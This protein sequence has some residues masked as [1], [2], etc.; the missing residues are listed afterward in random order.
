MAEVLHSLVS[1]D[2]LYARA[3]GGRGGF[4]PDLMSLVDGDAA[5]SVQ[6]PL[7]A[8]YVELGM[9]TNAAAVTDKNGQRYTIMRVLRA[10][11]EI[12]RVWAALEALAAASAGTASAAA[13][14]ASSSAAAPAVS[15]ADA[16][17]FGAFAETLVKEAVFLLNDA[18]GRLTDVHSRQVRMIAHL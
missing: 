4:G 1:T 10:L 8:L 18:L 6:V 13:G 11:W 17:A 12:P 9:H 7:I 2:E 14:A 16:D 5:Q 3:S 15:K